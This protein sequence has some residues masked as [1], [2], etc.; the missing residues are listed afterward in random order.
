MNSTQ[1]NTDRLEAKVYELEQPVAELRTQLRHA[2][3]EGINLPVKLTET[4]TR[5]LVLLYEREIVNDEVIQ[6]DLRP[7]KSHYSVNPDNLLKVHLCSLRKKLKPLGI[8]IENMRGRGYR[9]S[10]GSRER[11]DQLS[12]EGAKAV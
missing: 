7:R 6:T 9:L 12:S 3:G 2:G 10:S 8:E 4:K 1:S 5:L 11:I